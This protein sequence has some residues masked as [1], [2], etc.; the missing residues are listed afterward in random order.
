[1]IFINSLDYWLF[2]FEWKSRIYINIFLSFDLYIIS[3][4][5][6]FFDED[7]YWI[8][9]WVFNYNI[10]HY[11]DD[12]LFIQD[13]NSKFFDF[14]V[15]YLNLAEK[16]VKHRD[17]QVIDFTNIEFD[18]YLMK[19]RLSKNKYNHALLRIKY[20]FYINII[21]Y[22]ILEKLLEFLFFYA[23]V[24]SLNHFFL[25]NLFNLLNRLSHFHLYI[26]HYLFSV[27]RY[28]LLW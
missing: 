15:I 23:K 3:F 1:M 8:L 11:L 14:L 28:D 7:L 24:I 5:F 9:K 13:S 10:I 19:A 17:N 26:I 16:L 18:I 25:Y 4:I 2:L 20:L 6:N 22:Y 21:I 12:F 27:I